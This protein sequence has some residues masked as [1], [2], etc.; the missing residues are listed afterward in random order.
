MAFIFTD[1]ALE[2]VK[3]IEPA[4][5]ADNRGFF[6]ESY[7]RR[8]FA[9]AGIT[10]DFVQDNHSWSRRGVLRGLHFQKEYPQGKL[11]RVVTGSVLDVAVDI[12]PGSSAFGRW[13]TALLSAS[14]RRQLY[15]PPG[16]AHGFLALEDDVNLMYKCTQLY[17]PQYD[18]GII[19]N[20]P[21]I[22]I[23]WGLEQAGL[24]L[25]DLILS[26]KDLALPVLA[27]AL[28]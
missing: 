15:I 18:A 23:D 28:G 1:T 26:P 4:A 9:D 12:R 6:M 24:S 17:M 13:V 14:N 3:I 10:E 27:G 21:A 7:S 8:D 25:S 20:D 11:V 22:G 5:Y 16:F 2:G 19:W